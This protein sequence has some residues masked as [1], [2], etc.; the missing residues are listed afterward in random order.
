MKRLL[1]MAGC[2]LGF[3]SSAVYAQPTTTPTPSYKILLMKTVS[4]AEKDTFDELLTQVRSPEAQSPEAMLRLLTVE[5]AL[6]P[7][8]WC[9]AS[10]DKGNAQVCTFRVEGLQDD[11]VAGEV[12]K[13]RFKQISRV[14]IADKIDEAWRCADGRGKSDAYHTTLCK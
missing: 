10:T 6:K 5:G 8:V 14:W 7:M 3:W 4:A 13:I 11:S 1:L 2:A 9:A 12:K